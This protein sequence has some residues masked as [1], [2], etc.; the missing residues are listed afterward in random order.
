MNARS[1]VELGALVGVVI[2]T[3]RSFAIDIE[4]CEDTL[5]AVEADSLEIFTVRVDRNLGSPFQVAVQDVDIEFHLL[6]RH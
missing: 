1:R 5:P 3:C 4:A 2:L 6:M